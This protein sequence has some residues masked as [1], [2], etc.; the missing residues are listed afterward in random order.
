MP[1]VIA[2]VCS[3]ALA[4]T[5]TAAGDLAAAR[6]VCAAG[7]A[8]SRDVGDPWNQLMFGDQMAVLDLKAGRTGPAAAHL[9]EA[10]QIGLRADLHAELPDALDHCGILCAQTGRPAEALTLWAAIAAVYRQAGVADAPSEARFRHEPLRSARQALG[11]ARTR[12]AEDRG[13]AMTS[14]DTLA[15]YAL[16]LTTPG[17]RP[18]AADT[19]GA[20]LSAREQELVILVAQGRT[21]A[22][23]A[24]RL[25][26]SISTVGSHLGRIRDKT[27]CRNRADL[28]QLA[29]AAG[30]V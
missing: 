15:A 2:R 19:S 16:M 28:T 23:I 18:P 22:Q 14:L 30:L 5:L 27:G 1:G 26:I 4:W 12:A 8:A 29:L 11:A 20:E 25:D 3:M 6:R 17:P 24:A 9:N 10:I 7:L 13:A 21:D